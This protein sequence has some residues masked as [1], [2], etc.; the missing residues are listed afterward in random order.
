MHGEFLIESHFFVLVLFPE[1]VGLIEIEG[2]LLHHLDFEGQAS[3]IHTVDAELLPQLLDVELDELEEKLDILD[4]IACDDLGPCLANAG[5]VA[6]FA[7]VVLNKSEQQNTIAGLMPVFVDVV[8]QSDIG[9][10]F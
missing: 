4:Q 10:S 2:E 6:A 8:Q 3:D 9:N 7:G 1:D 5:R